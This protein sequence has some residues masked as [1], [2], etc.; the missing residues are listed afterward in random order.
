[1]GQKGTQR[2][3]SASGFT[4]LEL[5][6]V[7]AIVAVLITIAIPVFRSHQLRSK[8]AEVRSNL[9]ALR[10]LEESYSSVHDQY[11]AAPAEPPGIPGSISAD[12]S[13]NAAFTALGFDPE[14]HVYFSYGVAV[15]ADAAGYTADAAADIDGDGFPQLWGFAKPA[16][17]GALVAGE[18]GCAVAVL[19]IEIGPCGPGHG[20]SVY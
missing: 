11:I 2:S 1:M 13:P 16:P 12:F 20:T 5:M 8:S 10:A 15:T 14:G 19:G 4:L 9:G 3:R 18:V 17:S 7:L 6:V